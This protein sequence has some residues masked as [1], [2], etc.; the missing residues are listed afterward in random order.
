MIEEKV[1]RMRGERLPK[2][3]RATLGWWRIHSSG[4][5]DHAQVNRAGFAG[6]SIS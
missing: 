1:R 3:L 2:P 5:V 4:S 6:G